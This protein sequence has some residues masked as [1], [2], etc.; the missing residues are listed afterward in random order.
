MRTWVTVTTASGD[1]LSINVNHI[2]YIA[3]EESAVFIRD[4]GRRDL[5]RG[6]FD[7]ML[8]K[9]GIPLLDVP[10]A[11]KNRQEKCAAVGDGPGKR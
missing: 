7:E 3:H 10:D 6:A 11:W 1:H 9:L 4:M 5:T 8:N 2:A